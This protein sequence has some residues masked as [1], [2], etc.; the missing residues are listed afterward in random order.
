MEEAPRFRPQ[1]KGFATKALH[2]GQDPGQWKSHCVVIP[3]TMSATFEQPL[4]NEF[5]VSVKS[6]IQLSGIR[7]WDMSAIYYIYY[8]LRY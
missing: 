1:P 4:P 2:T 3:I 6:M 8:S 7:S 5:G